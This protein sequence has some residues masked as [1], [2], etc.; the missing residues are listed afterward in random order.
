MKRYSGIF[1]VL[2][3]FMGLL[4][5]FS[6]KTKPETIDMA[7]IATVKKLPEGHRNFIACFYPNIVAANNK[8]MNDRALILNLRDDYRHVIIRG[9]KRNWLNEMA[10]NYKYDDDFFS[11]SLDKDSYKQRIDSLLRR[12]DKIPPKLVMAQAIIE[13]GWGKSKFAREINNYF[14]IHCYRKGCG[15]PPGDI[16]DPK[17]YVKAFPSI[18]ACVEEYLWVLNCG[19]AYD[20]LR[21]KR[22]ELRRSGKAD[23][24][25]LLAEGLTRYS[26]KGED[27]VKLIHSIISGYLPGNMAAF[28]D[29]YFQNHQ[30]EDCE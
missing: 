8:I 7:E 18:E 13:S 16:E 22:L 30:R 12:V 1:N 10:T 26:E 14:G 27:Y 6:C 11:D 3:L 29:H 4:F 15:Q 28:S 24:A 23:S 25:M 20:G 5:L 21:E 9:I 17:F 2:Y 19:F